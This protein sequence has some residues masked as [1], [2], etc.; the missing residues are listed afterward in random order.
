MNILIILLDDV[1][2]DQLSFCNV[3][4]ATTNADTPAMVSIVEEGVRFNY[5]YANGACS[6]TRATIQTGS[7]SFRTAPAPPYLRAMNCS[8]TP[9]PGTNS[10]FCGIVG[11]AT[12]W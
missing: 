4:N 5:V 12:S 6:L 3:G 11:S 8:D 9:R 7:Y 10:R 1:G 2:V